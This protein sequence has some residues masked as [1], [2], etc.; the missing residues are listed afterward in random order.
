MLRRAALLATFALLATAAPA[1]AYQFAG[2][3]WPGTV[4]PYA[5]DA[6]SYE[7]AV[8]S[9]ARA[10]NRS[11]IGIRFKRV[12]LAQ[13][14]LVIHS[15]R[16]RGAGLIGCSGE[17]GQAMLGWPGPW[18]SYSTIGF[19]GHCRSRRNR[20]LIAMH[21][22]GH[23]LGLDHEDRHCAL[24]NSSI[25]VRAALPRRCRGRRAAAR[26]RRGPLSDDVRGARL[27]YSRPSPPESPSVAGFNAHAARPVPA[28]PVAFSAGLRNPRLVYR[29]NFD[30]PG[31]G[32]ANTA[33]GLDASHAFTGPGVYEVTLMVFDGDAA[34]ATRSRELTVSSQP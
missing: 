34:I 17:N 5:V 27:L 31:S 2:K 4:V 26:L 24:M 20:R 1:Q 18:Y 32:S 9:A 12:P 19:T 10:W 29:W 22:L 7:G 21:E 6:P 11:R 16:S 8:D 30:D 15:G 13:A 14:R 25:R 28:R 33:A 3:R 23:A